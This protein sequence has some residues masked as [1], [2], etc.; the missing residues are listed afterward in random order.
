MHSQL[1]KM[2]WSGSLVAGSAAVLALFLFDPTRVPIFPVCVFHKWTGL[3]CPGCGSLRALHQLLHGHINA[4][5]VLS[6]PL[7]GWFGFRL[8]RQQFIGAPAVEV[9]PFWLW[10]Y[11]GLWLAF[12]IARDLPVPLFTALS[13]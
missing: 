7:F 11:L 8:V 1:K 3:N 13:P 6:L 4:M 2:S 12:G 9:R 5:L 10:L